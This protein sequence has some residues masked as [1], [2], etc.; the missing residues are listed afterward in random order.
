MAQK[1]PGGKERKKPP[2]DR[3]DSPA[4]LPKGPSVMALVAG[5]GGRKDGKRRGRVTP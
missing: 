1:R 4:K 2:K 5:A 3:S